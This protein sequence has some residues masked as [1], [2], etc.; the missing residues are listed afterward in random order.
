[1]TNTS[2]YLVWKG[3]DGAMFFTVILLSS[4]SI[5][6]IGLLLSCSVTLL[7]YYGFSGLSRVKWILEITPALNEL[8]MFVLKTTLLAS[9]I[10]GL[11]R[12]KLIQS[13]IYLAIF[14]YFSSLMLIKFH[15]LKISTYPQSEVF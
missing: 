3:D 13:L 2:E 6:V 4:L 5:T 10:T 8:H 1:M 7:T 12:Y 9:L 11:M 15:D 14:G